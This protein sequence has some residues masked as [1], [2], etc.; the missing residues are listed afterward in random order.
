MRT[1]DGA[2]LQ[3]RRQSRVLVN[4]GQSHMKGSLDQDTEGLVPIYQSF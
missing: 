3:L 2:R 1:G 4:C